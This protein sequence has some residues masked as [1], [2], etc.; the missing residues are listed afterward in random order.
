MNF[1]LKT[2][3]TIVPYLNALAF[4][5]QG[6]QHTVVMVQEKAGCKRGKLTRDRPA[7][8]GCKRGNLTRGR[9]AIGGWLE[10]NDGPNPSEQGTP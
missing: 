7:T 1:I 2:K 8:R 9:P 3:M 4:K 5:E 6:T 10:A